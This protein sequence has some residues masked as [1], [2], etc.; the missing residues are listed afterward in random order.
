MIKN[1]E[2]IVLI[3]S[4]NIKYYSNMGY[5]CEIGKEISIDVNTMPKKSHNK[6]IAIC[7]ICSVENEI[8][9]DKY[10]KSKNS[11]GFYSC[12]K[13]ASIKS[14]KTCL[15]KY[16]VE[17]IA[18]S[19]N[20]RELNRAWMSSDEFKEKSKVTQFDKY[21]MLYTKTDISKNIV[22]IKTKEII[23]L[24]KENGIYECP[25][26]RPENN[27]LKKL[28]MFKKY[29]AEY[30]YLVPYIRNKIQNTNLEKYG[31]ISP[32]GNKDIQ[33]KIKSNV[34]YKYIDKKWLFNG[35][36]Y[37]VNEFNIYRRKVRYETDLVRRQLF[38]NWD[39]FDYY[40]GEYIKDNL[41]LNNNDNSYPSIDHKISCFYGF[42][43]GLETSY[44][45]NINN[46][47]ITKRII[48][49][50]KSQLNED[51]FLEIIKKE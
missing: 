22:S 41:N 48:N 47:C 51:E 35:D 14:K 46:L 3:T 2:S 16:G 20:V 6:V 4:R 15:D 38:E 25:L 43:N 50:R 10:N 39:G 11:Y 12:R 23:K 24:K 30:S 37:L 36:L 17:N 1:N 40:D 19:D 31:H 49:S 8:G 18:Q 9:F 33:S 26:S 34:I 7:E 27:N 32:F 21:G 45:S 13:C 44:I 28:G 29:G 5:V 42:I